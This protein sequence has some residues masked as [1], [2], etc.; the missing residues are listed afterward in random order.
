MLNVFSSNNSKMALS[1]ASLLSVASTSHPNPP[2]DDNSE[3][4]QIPDS[5]ISQNVITETVNP[6]ADQQLHGLESSASNVIKSILTA[7]EDEESKETRTENT[8]TTVQD[9]EERLSEQKRVESPLTVEPETAS[10]EGN[11]T[12]GK[13]HSIGKERVI[14]LLRKMKKR[15]RRTNPLL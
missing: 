14:H 8:E 12:Q 4:K 13:I 9:T 3:G 6:D 11:L 10:N 1:H 2:T 7:S 15:Y 5:E